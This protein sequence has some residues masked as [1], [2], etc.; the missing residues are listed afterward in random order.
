MK[1]QLYYFNQIGW[2][3]NYNFQKF[4]LYSFIDYNS[5]FIY[6]SLKLKK[7]LVFLLNSRGECQ[8]NEKN[9]ITFFLKSF[10]E[11]VEICILDINILNFLEFGECSAKFIS[12]ENLMI[13]RIVFFGQCYVMTIFKM[14]MNKFKFIN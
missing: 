5:D 9:I 13:F 8:E 10:N 2:I 4:Y 7:K 1:D 12:L 6:P 3:S 14:F 11:K